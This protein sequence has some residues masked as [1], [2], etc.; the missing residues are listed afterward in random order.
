MLSALII[1]YKMLTLNDKKVT[2]LL[3]NVTLASKVHYQKQSC[4]TLFDRYY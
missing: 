3:K 4:D 2:N 1:I